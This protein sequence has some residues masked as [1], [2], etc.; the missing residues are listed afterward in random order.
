[1]YYHMLV[2]VKNP[3]GSNLKYFELDKTDKDGLVEEFLVPYLLGKQI[4][5]D[6]YFIQR[7]EIA[8]ILVEKSN[9]SCVELSK[10][11]NDT[12]DPGIVM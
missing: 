5:F 2:E 10:H 8:R 11:E 1:M 4:H 3:Q 12:M 6:G 9:K 7:D